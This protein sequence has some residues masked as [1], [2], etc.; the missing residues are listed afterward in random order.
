M[1]RSSRYERETNETSVVVEVDLDGSGSARI[2]TGIGFFDHMLGLLARHAA[3]DLTVEAKGDLEVDEHH[4]VED[5]GLALGTALG[6]A[7]GE[8]RGIRRY[9]FLLPMDESLA[10]VA[11]DLGGRPYLVFD[12]E[13]TRERVGELPTELVEDFFKALSDTLKA[14]VHI[15]L[16]Y[17]RNDHHKIEAIFKAFARA[18]R[19]AIEADPQLGDD[20]PSTKG[21]IG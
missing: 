12:A 19:M 14:N 3:I 5:V 15:H 9:G 8:R 18:L 11:L 7:L 2:S 21:V 20:V 13:L 10:Q 4:T 6:R 17:G 16:H 1:S